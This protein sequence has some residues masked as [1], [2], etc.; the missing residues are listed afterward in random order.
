VVRL[1]KE[2][3][4]WGYRRI[5]G[6]LGKLG[7][8]LAAST[9]A[10]ILK[11]HGFGPAPRRSGPTWRAFLRA[12][13]SGVVATDFFHVDT[14]LL[15]RL[16]VLFFIELGRRRIW[17]TG[18]T[19][20]PNGGWVTQQARNV[21]SELADQEI[22]TKFLVRD[23]DTKYV[24]SFDNAFRA[25]G[26]EILQTPPFGLRTRTPSPNGSCAP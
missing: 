24:G 22:S 14:V 12:Q 7:V 16:Y 19:A 13:A 21:T 6:E 11:D 1:A 2:N 5:Q 17:I 25:E 26:A 18:V 10:K 9:I 3:P 8:R 23:R 15:K 20:H 4:R